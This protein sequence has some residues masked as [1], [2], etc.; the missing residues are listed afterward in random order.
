MGHFDIKNLTISNLSL[1][2][3]QNMLIKADFEIVWGRN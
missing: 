2:T 1:T 3:N